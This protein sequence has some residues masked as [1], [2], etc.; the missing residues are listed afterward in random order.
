MN[1]DLAQ[2]RQRVENIRARLPSSIS[3]AAL[4][5]RPTAPYHLLLAREALV[6]RTEELARCACDM[7]ERDDLAAGILLTRAVTESAAFVWRLK[8]LLETRDRYS[9]K[10]LREKFGRML[11]GE[12]NS[13]PH[14]PEAFNIVPLVERMDKQLPGVKQGYDHLS[15]F[16]HPNWSGV[17]G[18]FATHDEPNYTTTFGRGVYGTALAKEIACDLLLMSLVVFESACDSISAALPK[19]LAELEPLSA[20]EKIQ[21]T[22]GGG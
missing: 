21:M 3:V 19:F 15:G 8:E 13:D 18:L 10:E 12:K 1:T 22:P 14:L 11:F 6:W 17:F 9:D 20:S 2:A 4:G 16:A 5:V 7:L